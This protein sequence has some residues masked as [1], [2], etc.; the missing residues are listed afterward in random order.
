M[1][2]DEREVCDYLKT[3]RGQ[4]VAAREIS[5]KAAGKWRFRE[6]PS[7]AVPVLGRLVERGMVISDGLGHF[8]LVPVKPKNGNKRWVSPEIKKILDKSGKPFGGV[9]SIDEDGGGG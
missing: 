1:D 5:K 7:W 3:F 9:I 6:N 2:A 8:K 4:F